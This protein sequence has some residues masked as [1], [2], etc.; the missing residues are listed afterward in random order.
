MCLDAHFNPIDDFMTILLSS[1]PL[2]SSGTC[3]PPRLP[4]LLCLW[5]HLARSQDEADKIGG[6]S[7]YSTG[8]FCASKRPASLRFDTMQTH[9]CIGDTA[10]DWVTTQYGGVDTLM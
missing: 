4:D 1:S 7:I 6:R 10:G 5:R 3:V 8:S 2:L 9:P